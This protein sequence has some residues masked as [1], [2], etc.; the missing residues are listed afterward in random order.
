MLL[1]TILFGNTNRFTYFDGCWV[2]F[3]HDTG[4]LGTESG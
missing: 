2:R 3:T 1:K 4:P